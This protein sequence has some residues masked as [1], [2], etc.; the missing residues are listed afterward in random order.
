MPTEAE[1]THAQEVFLEYGPTPRL[2]IDFVVQ[3]L[4]ELERYCRELGWSDLAE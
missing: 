4:P 2:C 3:N 1:R